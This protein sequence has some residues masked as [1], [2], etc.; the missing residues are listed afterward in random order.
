MGHL[1]GRNVEDVYDALRR[2]EGKTVMTFRRQRDRADAGIGL[3]TCDDVL[4]RT[5][6]GDDRSVSFAGDVSSLTQRREYDRCG[7]CA[8]FDLFDSGDFANV[9]DGHRA[10]IFIGDKCDAVVVVKRDLVRSASGFYVRDWFKC[11]GVDYGDAVVGADPEVMLVVWEHDARRFFCRI[12]VGD[13]FPR[14]H[15]DHGELVAQRHRDVNAFVVG[16]DHPI[17]ARSLQG[18]ERE[19]FTAA[20]ARQ[21][22]DYGNV[23]F[24]V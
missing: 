6:D 4:L 12:D 14:G 13:H 21:R 11:D 18:N 22:I 5:A 20:K 19:Q 2:V 24:V 1:V 15:V 7:L 10:A 9:D 23:W 3:D 8:D 17:F 16:R